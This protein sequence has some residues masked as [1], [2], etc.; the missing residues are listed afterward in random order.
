MRARTCKKRITGKQPLVVK[1]VKL[2]EY[3]NIIDGLATI[4]WIFSFSSTARMTL[5]MA[6]SV[7]IIDI[8]L[9]YFQ[10][11]ILVE[12]KMYY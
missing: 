12:V 11:G 5:E 3:G 1:R 2:F 7:V 9:S 4:C 6:A 10:K 8:F